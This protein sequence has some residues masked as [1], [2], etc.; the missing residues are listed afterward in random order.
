MF[1]VAEPSEVTLVALHNHPKLIPQVCKM[2]NDQ[3]PRSE[4][5]RTVFLRSSCSSL[6]TSYVLL[7]RAS[8]LLGHLRVAAS[9]RTCGITSVVSGI[10]T[11]VII[12]PAYR[13]QGHGRRL[14]SLVEEQCRASHGFGRVVLW[15]NDQVPFY[16]SCGYVKCTPLRVVSAAASTLGSAGLNTLENML[17]LR[18]RRPPSRT[19]TTTTN[20]NNNTSTGNT[21]LELSEEETGDGGSATDSTWL[22]KRVVKHFPPYKMNR[23]EVV[24]DIKLQVSRQQQ[25]QQQQQLQ[26]PP[27]LCLLIDVPNEQQIGPCCGLAALRCVCEY[28]REQHSEHS[29]Q[30][31]HAQHPEICKLKHHAPQDVLDS[32]CSSCDEFKHTV[33]ATPVTATATAAAAATTSTTST[34]TPS[35]PYTASA[36]LLTIAMQNKWTTD[37]E[38]FN[39]LRLSQLGSKYCGLETYVYN[40]MSPER[41]I[42]LIAHGIPIMV[43]FD[44]SSSHQE[45]AV[46]VD[47]HGKRAHWGIVRGVVICNNKKGVT[48]IGEHK[49]ETEQSKTSSTNA[50]HTMNVVWVNDREHAKSNASWLDLYDVCS[51]IYVVLQHTAHGKI[52]AVPFETVMTSNAQIDQCITSDDRNIGWV[53]TERHLAETWLIC[54]PPRTII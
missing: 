17:K 45:H 34:T 21:D 30:S 38:M 7:D 54:L 10:V 5:S 52:S 40:K 32:E 37:G 22:S 36:P 33:V 26:L 23:K 16:K 51:Q 44:K 2:L 25:Q 24:V 47:T 13:R 12:H 39:T 42:E 46:S 6:P 9:L 53:E 15:T 49:Q 28:W 4:A 41:L 11:S 29:E 50:L 35:A 19:T 20:N 8:N 1:M 3:W 14:L 31:E 18:A 27:R 43:P 48:V